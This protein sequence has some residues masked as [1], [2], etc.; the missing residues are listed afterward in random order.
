MKCL[1]CGYETDINQKII[2]CPRCGGLLEIKVKLKGFSFSN[3]KGR[4]VWRYKDAIPGNYSKIVSINEVN[5]PLIPSRNYKQT[6]YKFE[7]ANPTGS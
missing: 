4:G 3:L 1:D 6:F 2:T 7:G 5:T